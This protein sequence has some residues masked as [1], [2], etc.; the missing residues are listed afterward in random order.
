L[1]DSFKKHDEM[2]K[3]FS[4]VRELNTPSFSNHQFNFVI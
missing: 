1:F 4:V 2:I 3:E